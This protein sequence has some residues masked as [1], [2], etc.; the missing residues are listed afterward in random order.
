M[1]IL[2]SIVQAVI[3]DNKAEVVEF[4][5]TN[6]SDVNEFSD[7]G[8]T[9]L[10]LSAYF[11]QKEIASFLLESGADI[12]SRAKNENENTPLQAAIANKQSELVAFLIEK[13][14]DINV[15]QSGGWTGLHEAALLG[16]E[17]IVMLLLEN[18]AN[19]AIKK[20]DGK[21]AYDIALEKGYDHLFHHIKQ[22]VNV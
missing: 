6:P 7:D 3:S 17:E 5:K 12:H 15:I 19:K 4:I 20:N 16:S 8:W 10:H 11:G 9:L 2:Q 22:E 18:G 1:G 14:A 13:G 21:T